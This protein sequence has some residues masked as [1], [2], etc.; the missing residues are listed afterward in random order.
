MCVYALNHV[1]SSVTIVQTYKPYEQDLHEF[2]EDE[3][4]HMDY[5]KKETVWQLPEFGRIFS[6]NAQIGLGDIVVDMTNL[7]QLIRQTSHTQ[8]TTVTSEV[9]MFP[10]EAVELEEPSVLLY[11]IDK[12]SIPVINITW[13]CNGESVTTAV[14]E[15][16][17]L[18]QDDCYSHKFHY[19]T[20]FLSTDDIY[21]CVVEP[22]GLKNHF[23]SVGI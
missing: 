11:H 5:E 7:N 6:S 20:F 22:W 23:S 9:A 18:P 3:P 4:F 10:K 13:L 16:A 19:F 12:F 8:V 2:D 14:S 17:F 21:D 1:I 15:T